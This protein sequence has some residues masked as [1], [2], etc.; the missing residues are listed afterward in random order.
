MRASG[1]AVFEE[2]IRHELL[3]AALATGLR[4]GIATSN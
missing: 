1:V 2:D 3:A 4:I